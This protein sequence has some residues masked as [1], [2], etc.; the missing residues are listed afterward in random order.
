MP[1]IN[2]TMGPLTTEQKKEIIKRVTETLMDITKIPEHSFTTI[3]NEVPLENIGI[4]TMTVEE[5]M[6]SM[7]K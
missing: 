1:I 2:L 7:K 3:I 5:K 6:A 4:G